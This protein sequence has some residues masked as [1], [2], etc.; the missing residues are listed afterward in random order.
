MTVLR[1]NV[2]GDMCRV[3]WVRG[4]EGGG[5]GACWLPSGVYVPL[6]ALFLVFNIFTQNISCGYTLELPR[7]GGSNEYPQ[8]LFWSKNKKNRTGI[9]LHTPVLLYKSGVQGGGDIHYI[10]MFS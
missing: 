9:P 3:V 10:D 2:R 1:F 4:R 6:K 8:S 5:G 7:Q